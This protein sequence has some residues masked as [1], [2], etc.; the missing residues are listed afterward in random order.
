METKRDV[1]ATRSSLSFQC[2]LRDDIHIDWSESTM[3]DGAA[4][5][6]GEGESGVKIN[7]GELLLNWGLDSCHCE[8]YEKVMGEKK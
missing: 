3:G 4:Q 6:T 7:A 5:S 8:L 1:A 2:Q